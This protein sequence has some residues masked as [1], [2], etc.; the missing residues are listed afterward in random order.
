VTT[1][2]QSLSV[3][4]SVHNAEKRLAPLVSKMLDMLSDMAHRF[5][6]LILDDGST[7]QTEEV[8]HELARDY[9]QMRVAHHA[10][11]RGTDASLRT[12]L[13]QT[14]GDVVI[15]QDEDSADGLRRAWELHGESDRAPAAESRWRAPSRAPRPN[16]NVNSS[17]AKEDPSPVGGIHVICRSRQADWIIARRDDVATNRLPRPSSLRRSSSGVRFP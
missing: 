13:E 16:P 1:S 7:D 14:T 11:R 4:L 10:E 17:S 9:P 6:L 3:V 5:E 2:Q 12:A 15:L 8:A